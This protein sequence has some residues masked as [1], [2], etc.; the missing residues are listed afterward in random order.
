M[1]VE[2]YKLSRR[3]ERAFG[4]TEDIDGQ[5]LTVGYVSTYLNAVNFEPESKTV[6]Q[7]LY[8]VRVRGGGVREGYVVELY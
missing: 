2:V 6:G 3:P 7:G 4:M 1:E 8:W 5:P